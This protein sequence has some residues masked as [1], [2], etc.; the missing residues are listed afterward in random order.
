MFSQKAGLLTILIFSI[1]TL[2]GQSGLITNIDSRRSISLNGEWQY[3]MDPYETGF[4]DYRYKERKATD[5][6]AYWNT[7]IPANKT[8]KKEYGYSKKYTL[9]VPGDWN[10]QRPEFLYYEG[11]VWYKR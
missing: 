10:H 4:Y 11:S 2:F 1:T 3:V 8:A 9:K 6:D 7:D 5:N